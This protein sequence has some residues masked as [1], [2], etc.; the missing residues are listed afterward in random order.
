[1]NDIEKRRIIENVTM[2][3]YEIAD[4]IDWMHLNIEQRKKNYESWTANPEIGGMLVPIV[5]INGVRVYLK[6]SLMK[7]YVS[8]RRP[9]IKDLLTSMSINCSQILKEYEKPQAI[10]CDKKRLYTLTTAKEWKNSIMTA[11][12]RRCEIGSI[13]SNVVL[14]IEHVSG[15]FVDKDYRGLI[16]SAASR[17]DVEVYWVN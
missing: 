17:L 13:E 7:T 15:R 12:E 2:K 4:N 1:M 6:D 5:G 11:F 10:L 8:L 16:E 9:M 14:V 3:I